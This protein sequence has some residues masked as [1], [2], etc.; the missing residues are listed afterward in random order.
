M[1]RQ[2]LNLGHRAWSEMSR[3]H[4]AGGMARF[5]YAGLG[6]WLSLLEGAVPAPPAWPLPETPPPVFIVGHWRSGTTL[7][8]ELLSASGAFVYPTTF[9]CMNPQA[10]LLAGGRVSPRVVET[11]RPMDNMLLRTDLPQEDEFALFC[12]GAP[13]AY[14]AAIFPEAMPELA[15]RSDPAR[16]NPEERRAWTRAFLRFSATCQKSAPAMP[17]LLKSPPHSFKISLIEGLIPS[18][19]F[20]HI[21]R[22]PED[23]FQSS[24]KLWQ[25]LWQMYALSPPLA[26]AQR[27]DA[28]LA[29][30]VALDAV[31]DGQLPRDGRA[32]TLRFE[33]LVARP[34]DILTGIAEFLGLSQD[35]LSNMKPR[36]VAMRGHKRDAAPL[37]GEERARVT[38]RCGAIYARHGY[39]L[40]SDL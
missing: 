34:S 39:G 7:L 1:P 4:S 29:S 27:D 24:R 40:P 28:I 37:S 23:V 30:Q 5:R 6:R 18:A 35:A 21:V 14:E 10:F 26:P 9:A 22:R 12:L 17:L 16:W 38:E 19:R 2:F 25:A 32:M 3:R 20:L 31:I 11:V 8:H 13:S 36:I 15:H 33:D